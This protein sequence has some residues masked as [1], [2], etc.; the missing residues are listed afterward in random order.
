MNSIEEL[1]QFLLNQNLYNL[2]IWSGES[3]HFHTLTT[4]DGM[5]Y[6]RGY[7]R[8]NLPL[9]AK[10]WIEYLPNTDSFV[11]RISY[12]T[13]A[14]NG[15]SREEFANVVPS[16]YPATR[17]TEKNFITWTR[18]NNYGSYEYVPPQEIILDMMRGSITPRFM[19]TPTG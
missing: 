15:I 6:Q 1:K 5:D 7:V 12:F 14:G 10:H 13:L 3:E 2:Y 11:L 4:P 16:S 9:D 19:P 18:K 8:A 17:Y